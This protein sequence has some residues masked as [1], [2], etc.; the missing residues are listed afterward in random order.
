MKKIYGCAVLSS[1]LL[2]GGCV[3]APGGDIDYS[4]D[5]GPSMDEHVEVKGITFDLIRQQE[6]ERKKVESQQ[7]DNKTVSLDFANKLSSYEYEIGRGDILNIIVY[8][9]PELTIPA[10]AERSSSD[11]GYVVQ[12]DGTIFYPYVG[13]IRVEGKSVTQVRSIISSALQDYVADPQVNVNI[14]SYRAKKAYVTGRVQ[15]PGP[16]PIT[17]IP[18][19]LVDAVTQAGGVT[20][21]AD[22][23]HIVLTRHGKRQVIS[24]YDLLEDGY[25]GINGLIQ[26]GDIIHVPDVGSQKVYVMGEVNRPQ[27]LPMGGYNLSLTDAIAQ[28]GG[29]DEL[30]AQPSGI[31][32]IRRNADSD[33]SGKEATV[34]QLDISNSA[35]FV[36]G[37]EF[38]LQPK[39]IVYVTAAPLARWNK[40][41]SLL[42][43]STNITR[44]G[45]SINNDF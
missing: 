8:D 30:Q 10:G 13:R 38:E 4:A 31:F 7:T 23:H 17:N 6:A 45:T 20:N 37:T 21:E 26:D 36:L 15:N 40:V 22:W 5:Q 2:L 14:A 1:A 12:R 33:T 39:D 43:P 35:A 11:S 24:L 44:Q 41:I 32:V 42:L 25:Q 19:T 29:I 27:A 9:H 34:Y 16:Q 3:M 28:S 18:L